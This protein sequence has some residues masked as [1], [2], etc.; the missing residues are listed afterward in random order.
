ML[1]RQVWCFNKIWGPVVVFIASVALVAPDL[2]RYIPA[3]NTAFTLDVLNWFGVGLLALEGLGLLYVV[4][5]YRLKILEMIKNFKLN[6][7]AE[8]KAIWCYNK[9][10][11]LTLSNIKS[12]PKEHPNCGSTIVV[13]FIILIVFL[14]KIPFYNLICMSLATEILLLADRLRL[15]FIPSLL[16]QKLT[17]REPSDEIINKAIKSFNTLL[18]LEGE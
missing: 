7:G 1:L 5:K 8:H 9:G 3:L 18:K 12:Q 13:W 6:H 14:H 10:L 2:V 11:D 17:T 15:F 16:L 4:C